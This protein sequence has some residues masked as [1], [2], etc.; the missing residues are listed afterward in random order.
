VSELTVRVPPRALELL[1][2]V[3][4][5]LSRGVEEI[6]EEILEGL[7]I[8]RTREDVVAYVSLSRAVRDRLR[9][10]Y[11]ELRALKGEVQ[12]LRDEVERLKSALPGPA[13]GSKEGQAVPV[14]GPA[15][16]IPEAV[17]RVASGCTA[18][19]EALAEHSLLAMARRWLLGEDVV[20]LRGL[21]S[22]DGFYTLLRCGDEVLA[23]GLRDSGP[24]RRLNWVS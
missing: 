10:M 11:L 16:E 1:R 13:E 8:R 23:S 7:A 14:P 3:A 18:F 5:E 17:R 6:V 24:P 20:E 19:A 12:R 9:L 15:A 21:L 4:F 22:D 2:A